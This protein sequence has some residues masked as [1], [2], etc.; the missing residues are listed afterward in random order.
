[1]SYSQPIIKGDKH[2]KMLPQGT[3]LVLEG[4]GTRGFYSAGVFEAFMDAG[5]IFPYIVGVSAGAANAISYISGQKLRSRVIIEKYV[6]DHRYVS[7]RNLLRHRTLFGYDFIF[8]TVPTRHVFFD[9]ENFDSVDITFL[10]GAMDCATGK[11]VWFE[12]N[13]ISDGFTVTRASCSVPL[14]AKIVK[15]NGLE[16]LDG[17]VSDPIPIEKSIEDGNDFHVIVLTRNQGYRKEAFKF[18]WL[19]KLF[20]KKYPQLIEAMLK[21]HEIYNRQLALCEELER[22][23]KALIIRPLK[24]ISVDRA[25]ADV[26]KL[27]ALYDEGH[28]EGAQIVSMLEKYFTTI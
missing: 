22:D 23:N 24:P 14:I 5:I 27:L 15:H 21:R 26:N 1:M 18:G 11:T 20:Y 4:G 6:G 25:S 28:V 3:A 16:L 19:V 13:E 17:G 10:T 12:K 7:R 9:R 2:T 8:E